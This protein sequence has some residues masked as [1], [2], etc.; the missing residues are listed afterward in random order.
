MASLVERHCGEA[1]PGGRIHGAAK[2]ILSMKN[3]YFHALNIF[4]IFQ[5]NKRTLQ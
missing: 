1:V 5:L 4:L 2:L 3:E